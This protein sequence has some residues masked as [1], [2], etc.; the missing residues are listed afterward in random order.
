MTGSPHPRLFS[1]Q[2]AS[3]VTCFHAN[4]VAQ[5]PVGGAMSFRS[6]FL[7]AALFTMSVA[8]SAKDPVPEPKNRWNPKCDSLV[9]QRLAFWV[10]E[11]DLDVRQRMG[12]DSQEF[13][14]GRA[15]ETFRIAL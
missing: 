13:R 1:P 4:W 15:R 9:M 5:E 10:G 11:W 14:T 6:C 12:A 2:I 7:L 3:G 8:V